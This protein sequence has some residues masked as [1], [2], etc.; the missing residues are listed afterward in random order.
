MYPEIMVVPMREEL[1]RVGIKE[2]RTAALKD[3]IDRQL[4]I[5]AFKISLLLRGDNGFAVFVFGCEHRRQLRVFDNG[6][7]FRG[8]ANS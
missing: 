8:K 3:L 7:L 5:Q 4:I 6:A 2:A 1:T